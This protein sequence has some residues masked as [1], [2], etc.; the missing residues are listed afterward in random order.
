MIQI[1]KELFTREDVD[2]HEFRIYS[3]LAFLCSQRGQSEL[4]VTQKEISQMCNLS[5]VTVNT[6]MQSLSAKGLIDIVRRQRD[7]GSQDSSLY[8]LK[9]K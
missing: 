9:G 7:N 4:C 6:R 2:V 1:P 5:R 8:I 3:Q